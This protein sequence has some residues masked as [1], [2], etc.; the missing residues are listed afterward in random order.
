MAEINIDI[1]SSGNNKVSATNSIIK[2]LAEKVEQIFNEIVSKFT[3]IRKFYLD[4]KT[5]NDSVN[6][7]IDE[8]VSNVETSIREECSDYLNQCKDYACSDDEIETGVYS[9]KHYA[10]NAKEWATAD[11]IIETS[12][13]GEELYS[14]KNYAELSE[15]CKNETLENKNTIENYVNQVENYVEQANQSAINAYESEIACKKNSIICYEYLYAYCAG[16]LK[17]PTATDCYYIKENY[18]TEYPQYNISVDVYKFKNNK[19]ELFEGEVHH[20]QSNGVLIV[21]HD[22]QNFNGNG[23]KPEFNITN[24]IIGELSD[25]Y[26]LATKDEIPTVPTKISDFINDAGYLTEHQDIS[27]LATKDEIPD[28]SYKQDVIVDL[29]TIRAGAELGETALQEETDPVYLADKP[30]LALKS[31]IKTKT[32]ELTND[33]NFITSAYHDDTK[34][35]VI[36]DLYIIRSGAQAGSTALQSY[37]ETDPIYMADKPNIA[38]KSE[39]PDISGKADKSEIPDIS[40]LATKDEIPTVP[41]KISELE[42][43]VYYAT[44]SD[45][46]KKANKRDVVNLTD[47]QTVSGKKT[48]SDT[49]IFDTMTAPAIETT[50]SYIQSGRVGMPRVTGFE[51][52]Y[53]NNGDG[54][55]VHNYTASFKVSTDTTTHIGHR[56]GDPDTRST[57]DDSYIKF[58]NSKLIYGKLRA[59]T[60]S[61]YDEY[62]ILHS[63]NSYTK[64][65]IDSM[66]SNNLGNIETLLREV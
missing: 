20:M 57:T 45:L 36:D 5:L 41:T 34:Q 62:N 55:N 28:I 40:N 13:D 44:A 58:D 7:K 19:L 53:Q 15:E 22:W 21:G 30:N 33:S 8:A 43:D 3:D 48:F 64:E 61:I 6:N 66:F 51:T 63:G 9:A 56:T 2:P 42:N 39:I 31:E 47:T 1:K 10:E 60:S 23:Y 25:K 32:S 29:D 17:N 27:N 49:A 54:L 52:H 4:T 26:N 38:L 16:F 46:V 37:T 59:N 12:E 65:E 24:Y 11:G 18:T 50:Y 14:A 35:D